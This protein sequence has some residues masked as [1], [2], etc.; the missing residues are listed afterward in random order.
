M[1]FN[2]T[3]LRKLIR[4]TESAYAVTIPKK[5]REALKVGQGNYL[6]ISMYDRETLMLRKS[7]E[8]KK[9]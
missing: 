7:P 5:Y 4:L 3:E 2:M 1:Q 8:P 9:I 6:E